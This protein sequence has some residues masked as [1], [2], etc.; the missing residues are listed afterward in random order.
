[1]KR[2]IHFLYILKAG[3]IFIVCL[4]GC[5]HTASNKTSVPTECKK[6]NA[7]PEIRIE[8]L[9]KAPSRITIND[10][11]LS[12]ETYLW[13]N[14][15]P[16]I[17]NSGTVSSE[18]SGWPLTAIARVKTSDKSP[19]P[20]SLVVDRLWIIKNP[21]VWETGFSNETRPN[22]GPHIIEKIA[23]KGPE[24][25]GIHSVDVVVRIKSEDAEY[26]IKA[27]NQKIT[28]TF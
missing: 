21:E 20:E 25:P 12:L 27:S 10:K 9:M 28:Q 2:H 24:W 8:T 19:V 13:K 4:S 3:L 22:K 6:D 16:T 18:K 7:T 11:A 1:M 17:I 15:Q 23:R 14:F 5:K 26:L